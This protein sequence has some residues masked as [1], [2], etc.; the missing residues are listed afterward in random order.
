MLRTWLNLRLPGPC[1]VNSKDQ[2]NN[3]YWYITSLKNKEMPSDN[4][5]FWPLIMGN[6]GILAAPVHSLRPMHPI[7]W[8]PLRNYEWR[9]SHHCGQVAYQA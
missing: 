1:L 8:N 7:H 9:K 2:D 3:L 4:S 6:L 5:K